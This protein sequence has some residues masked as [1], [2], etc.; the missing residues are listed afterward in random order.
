MYNKNTGYSLLACPVWGNLFWV[1][2]DKGADRSPFPVFLF[3]QGTTSDVLLKY[4][5]SVSALQDLYP[6]YTYS[7]PQ[8][9]YRAL[10]SRQISNAILPEP[11]VSMALQKD[12]SLFVRYD[13]AKEFSPNGFAQTAVVVSSGIKQ[14]KNLLNSVDSLLSVS[15]RKSTPENPETES[16][17]IRYKIL[18]G[19]IVLATV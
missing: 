11:F 14:D 9:L 18:P 10:M 4:L 17:L 6:D 5:Q 13:L 1:S 15:V 3:G 12:S 19:K 16:R 7:T 8:D 2:S